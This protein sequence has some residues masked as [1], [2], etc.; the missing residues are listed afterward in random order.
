MEPYNGGMTTTFACKCHWCG[1]DLIRKVQGVDVRFHFCDRKC[2]GEYQRTQK[3]V[4]KEWLHEHYIV[5]GLDTTQIGHMVGRDPKSV[6]NW[7]KDFGIP[8]RPRGQTGN[9]MGNA[10]HP[11]KGTPP[12]FLGKKHTPETLA[13]MR[14]I[15]RTPETR[16]KIRQRRIADGHVPYLKDGKHWME[17]MDQSDHPNWKGGITAERQALYASEEWRE[18]VKAVWKRDDAI[19]QR[20]KLD[21]RTI[22]PADRKRFGFALHHMVGFECVELRAVVSNLILLCRYCHLWVHSKKNVNRDFIKEIPS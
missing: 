6:W 13:R 4:T 21:H 12:P 14:G 7:L 9:G 15:K 3:P 5:K 19:C 8:T 16:E 22:G 1:A 17:G 2:K 10:W 20:C 18:C 11:S